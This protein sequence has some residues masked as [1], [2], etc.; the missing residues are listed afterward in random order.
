MFR[1]ESPGCC[2]KHRVP[3]WFITLLP[4]SKNVADKRQEIMAFAA[5]WMDLQIVILSEVGQKGKDK[6]HRIS[7]LSSVQF[8]CSVVSD[9]LRPRGLQHNRFPCPSPTPGACSNSCPSSRWNAS[10]WNLNYDTNELIYETETDSQAY[11]TN[12]WS[13]RVREVGGGKYWE[14][15]IG[16]CELLYK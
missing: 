15:G 6:Y 8:S 2:Y 10:I 3:L 4:K 14:F 11:S 13:P 1:R 7:L 9:S 16:S 12:L 5:T